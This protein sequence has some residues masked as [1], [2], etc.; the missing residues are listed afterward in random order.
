MKARENGVCCVYGEKRYCRFPILLD[1]VSDRARS[2]SITLIVFLL[3]FVISSSL[4]W[5]DVEFVFPSL[6]SFAFIQSL[7]AVSI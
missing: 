7:Y 3:I 2:R 6:S 4:L 1:M 5:A